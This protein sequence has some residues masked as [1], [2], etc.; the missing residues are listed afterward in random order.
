[1]LGWSEIT[2]DPES[3]QY[4]SDPFT[5]DE[6]SATLFELGADAD[7]A[8]RGSYGLHDADLLIQEP[9]LPIGAYRH[10]AWLLIAERG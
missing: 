7:E 2:T 1:M 10:T 9:M 4:L 6:D 8:V 5:T 3:E